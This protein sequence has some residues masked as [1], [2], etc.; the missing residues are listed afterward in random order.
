MSN[1][2]SPLSVETDITYEKT[3]PSLTPFSSPLSK[4]DD[5]NNKTKDNHVELVELISKLSP[6]NRNFLM[7]K[8]KSDNKLF[9]DEKAKAK[10]VITILTVHIVIILIIINRFLKKEVLL[11]L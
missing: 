6:E 5:N 4:S 1:N 11:L 10:K 2:L 8:I 3:S 9:D 7:H